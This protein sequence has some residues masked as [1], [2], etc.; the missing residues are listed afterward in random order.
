MKTDYKDAKGVISLMCGDTRNI[1]PYKN[2]KELLDFLKRFIKNDKY[3]ID[4]FDF[5]DKFV[6]IVFDENDIK[7][8]KEELKTD[9]SVI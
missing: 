8:L 5:T 6:Y 2:N 7:E 4:V 9:N 3:G 1:L